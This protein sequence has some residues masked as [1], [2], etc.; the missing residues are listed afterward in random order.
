MR[1]GK[2]KV[3][4][5]YYD[6]E[7]KTKFEKYPNA[8]QIQDF[9]S[10]E[11]YVDAG[12]FWAYM[13]FKEKKPNWPGFKTY[14]ELKL[15]IPTRYGL[16]IDYLHFN[17]VSISAKHPPTQGGGYKEIIERYGVAMSLSLISQLHG[18]HEADWEVIPESSQKKT[19]DY[20]FASDGHTYIQVESKGSIIADNHRKESTISNHKRS[21]LEKKIT[22]RVDNPEDIYYGVIS[23]LDA[24]SDSV[25]QSWLVDPPVD[26]ITTTPQRDKLL[27]RLYYYWRNLKGVN[28]RSPLLQVL[29]NRIAV[30]SIADNYEQFD[31]LS[32]QDING[33]PIEIQE[34]RFA[35]YSSINDGEIVGQLI[36]I[37][38]ETLFFYGYARE[39]YQVLVDQN[40]DKIRF[41]EFKPS[42]DT[43]NEVN[44]VIRES[45]ASEYGVPQELQEKSQNKSDFLRFILNGE[46]LTNKAGRAFGFLS[47]PSENE[48]R[49]PSRSASQLPLLEV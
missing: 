31:N 5:D 45:K 25:A 18:F 28:P 46:I 43:Y 40:F 37:N 22:C 47:Y 26:V 23:V 21:I 30:L 34:G 44:C 24:R 11:I 36:P 12:D 48:E 9:L 10:R 13:M 7:E 33:E 35:N 8:K 27:K 39:I 41:Y 15:K 1:S 3:D 16:I 4:L 2:I 42:S 20:S 32:F 6:D 38:A 17:T 49:K 14:D 19:F 29:K